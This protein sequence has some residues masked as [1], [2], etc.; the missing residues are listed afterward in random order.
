MHLSKKHQDI[1]KTKDE[2]AKIQYE[3]KCIVA[4]MALNRNAADPI[5]FITEQNKGM[6]L[7][8]SE[9][10]WLRK[11]EIAELEAKKARDRGTEKTE[12]RRDNVRQ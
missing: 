7:R 10:N 5:K 2:L 1:R 12:M 8:K 3:K 9:K 6:E 11:S 4:E